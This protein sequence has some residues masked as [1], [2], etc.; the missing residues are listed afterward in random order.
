MTTIFLFKF[1]AVINDTQTGATIYNTIKQA[2]E[3]P[4]NQVEVEL[5]GVITMATFCAKQIF[6]RLYVEMGQSDFFARL[7]MKNATSD[8]KFII[9]TGIESALE[10]IQAGNR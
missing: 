10:D 6:G 9:R 1:G 3:K 7:I 5:L 8:L 2:L 4:S